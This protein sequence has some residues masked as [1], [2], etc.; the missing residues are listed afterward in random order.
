MLCNAL[1]S[2]MAERLHDLARNSID[3]VGVSG[4]G[5]DDAVQSAGAFSSMFS[6]WWTEH[7][8]LDALGLTE[9]EKELGAFIWVKLDHKNYKKHKSPY[10]HCFNFYIL[11][12]TCNARIR[13]FSGCLEMKFFYIETKMLHSLVKLN[14]VSITQDSVDTGGKR[15]HGMREK[16]RSKDKMLI[17]RMSNS[18]IFNKKIWRCF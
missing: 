9:I 10:G 11:M 4:G 1:E 16:W 15:S 6:S 17:G 8:E 18:E 5:Q 3:S 13:K 12:I 2:S 7:F 14:E